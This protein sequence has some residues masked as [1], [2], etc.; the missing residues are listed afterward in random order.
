[1]IVRVSYFKAMRLAAQMCGTSSQDHRPAPSSSVS[2][3]RIAYP[4]ITTV[5]PSWPPA[6]QTP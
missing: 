1:M 2:G 3:L 6:D 4:F 5:S